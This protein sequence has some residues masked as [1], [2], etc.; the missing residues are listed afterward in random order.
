MRTAL[1]FLLA[2]LPPSIGGGC[3][4]RPVPDA[5]PERHE[6]RV[7]MSADSTVWVVLYRLDWGSRAVEQRVRLGRGLS[8][9]QIDSTM[10]GFHRLTATYVKERGLDR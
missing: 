2:L 8:Q 4:C 9:E 1:F 10:T 5:E 7:E 6:T 3:G